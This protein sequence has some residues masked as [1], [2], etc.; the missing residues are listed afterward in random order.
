MFIEEIRK[1]GL[2]CTTRAKEHRARKVR[3]ASFE[4]I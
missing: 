2:G 3:E 4:A 1:R